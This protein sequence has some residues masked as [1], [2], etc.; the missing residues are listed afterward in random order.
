[1]AVQTL[2]SDPTADQLWQETADAH[3]AGLRRTAKR[4]AA[5]YIDHVLTREA[6]RDRHQ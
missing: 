3:A 1:M 4:C 6:D 2:T 5:A